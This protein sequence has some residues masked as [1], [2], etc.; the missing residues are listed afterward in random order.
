MSKKFSFKFPSMIAL[1]LFGAA[2][3]THHA[4]ASENKQ[5]AA[6]NVIDDQQNIENAN[7]AKHQV[8]NAAQN[9]SGCKLTKTLH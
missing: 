6:N 4:E 9:I 8:S 3:T 7:V 5:E 2:F 1:T